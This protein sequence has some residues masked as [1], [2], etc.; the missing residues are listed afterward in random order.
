MM[1]GTAKARNWQDNRQRRGRYE[2]T[3]P[4]FNDQVHVAA[5]QNFR[6]AMTVP[7]ASID[8]V[9]THIKIYR[10]PKVKIIVNDQGNLSQITLFTKTKQLIGK[11]AKNPNIS[12]DEFQYVLMS[13][14]A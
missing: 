2:T 14:L 3:E 11:V 8:L 6:S 1:L 10:Y 9:T 13:F 12:F 7:A 5:F 4:R